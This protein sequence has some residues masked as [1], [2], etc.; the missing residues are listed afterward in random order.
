MARFCRRRRP[1][2]KVNIRRDLSFGR[3]GR[4]QN[5]LTF[6]LR[7][8]ALRSFTTDRM[9][10]GSASMA[11]DRF[12]LP[13]RL[14]CFKASRALSK[15]NVI[16]KTTGTIITIKGREDRIAVSEVLFQRRARNFTLGDGV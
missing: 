4:L 13:S 9:R 3:T 10:N 12:P 16:R 8:I 7:P 14:V 5:Q 2:A 11:H 6:D 1:K 15:S